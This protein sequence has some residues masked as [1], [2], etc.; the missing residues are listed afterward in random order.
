MPMNSVAFKQKKR[1]IK[2]KPVVLEQDV[3][4]GHTDVMARCPHIFGH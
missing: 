3:L 1:N 2:L 4:Q